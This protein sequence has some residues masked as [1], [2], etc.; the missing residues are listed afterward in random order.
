[1]N[2]NALHEVIFLHHILSR[3]LHAGVDRSSETLILH[4]MPSLLLAF[5][6]SKNKSSP[7]PPSAAVCLA[8][9]PCYLQIAFL[10][11]F[12]QLLTQL[13]S[14]PVLLLVADFLHEK[15]TYACPFCQQ[16]EIYFL[17]WVGFRVSA[18]KCFSS[19]SLSLTHSHRT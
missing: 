8:E 10:A 9:K 2:P 1:M 12:C 17:Q 6:S 3:L 15:K 14:F 11:S 5:A 19:V 18:S 13:L 7:S 16:A 4:P